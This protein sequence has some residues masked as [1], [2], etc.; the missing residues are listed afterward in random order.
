VYTKDFAEAH[1]LPPENIST[2]LSPGVDYMEM[3]VMPSGKD[4]A[5]TACMANMLI[6]KPHDVA[7]YGDY[8][9]DGTPSTFIHPL[10]KDRKLAH[11]IDLDRFKGSL[12]PTVSFYPGGRSGFRISSYA[13]YVEDVLPGYDYFSANNHCRG[14]SMHPQSF[15]HGYGFW[16]GKAS[17][18][19]RYEMVYRQSGT[20]IP[21]GEDFDKSFFF[22][23]I[24]HELISTIFDG[25]PLGGK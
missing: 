22:V 7:M 20:P 23:N 24:P 19:G 16:I 11:F 14:V 18:W 2:D 21:Q 17:V 1:N 12:K 13:M 9:R 5:W 15:P 8:E 4:F 25:V 6:K 10:P 3:E